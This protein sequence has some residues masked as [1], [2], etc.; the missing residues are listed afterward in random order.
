MIV[1]Y[2]NMYSPF[3]GVFRRR[4]AVSISN[5]V[6]MGGGH[7]IGVRGGRHIF[8]F[9]KFDSISNPDLYLGELRFH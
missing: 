9:L 7:D 4:G 1:G 6:R 8:I 2:F 5:K 3:M